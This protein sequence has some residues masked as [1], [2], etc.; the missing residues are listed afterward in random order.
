M[1]IPNDVTE[2]EVEQVMEAI[3]K[4]KD[5]AILDVR[6]NAEYRRGHI[7]G[8]LNIP[9]DELPKK[10]KGTFKDK[11]RIIYVYCLSGSRSSVAAS[12]LLEMGYKNVFNVRSGLLSW[13]KNGYP[14]SIIE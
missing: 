6:T 8:S 10:V 9:V 7:A 11:N 14:L 1:L 2:I 12:E 13:R 4:G 5:V 3:T